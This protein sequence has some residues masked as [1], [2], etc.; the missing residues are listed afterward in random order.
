VKIVDR[1]RALA[2]RERRKPGP[3]VLVIALV[4][5]IG[6]G[7]FAVRALPSIEGTP[8]WW[9]LVIAGVVGVP[10]LAM[11]SALEYRIMGLI[12]GHRV[13]GWDAMR[14]T[15]LASA[16]NLLP[17]PGAAVV[18]M[19][20]LRRGGA[21]VSHAFSA[22]VVIGLAWLGTTGVIGGAVQVIARPWLALAFIAGGLALLAGAFGLVLRA[23]GAVYATQTLG[24]LVVVES[25]FVAAHGS[26]LFLTAHALHLHCSPAQAIS[27]TA[28]AVVASAAGVLPGGLGLREAL[29]AALAPAIGMPAAVGLVITAVDRVVSL[30]ALA[31]LSVLVLALERRYGTRPDAEVV[32]E[33]GEP[34]PETVM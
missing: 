22:T 20:G 10:A 26:K 6:S 4:I 29:A 33:V 13:R 14:V 28:A 21:R 2:S 19:E 16:A 1:A 27:L 12:V 31:I 3:W 23:R 30:I 8:R 24:R 25:G 15:I 18:R 11:I 32:L 7:V 34:P 17:I 9:M 5:F